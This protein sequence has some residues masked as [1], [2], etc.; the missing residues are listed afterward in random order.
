A[1]AL[2]ATVLA[3]VGLAIGGGFWLEWERGE[4]RAE[5]VRQEEREARAVEAALEQASALGRQGRWPDAR[6]VVEGGA[7]PVGSSA[8]ANLRERVMQARSDANMAAKLEGIRLRLSTDSTKT[9]GTAAPLYAEYAEAFRSYFSIDLLTL[10]PEEAAARVGNSAIRETL[11][12]YLHDWHYWASDAD[13]AKLQ[14]VLDRADDD[15]WRRAW[16]EAAAVRDTTVPRDTR[17]MVVLAAKTEALAQPPLVLSGLGGA[18]LWDGHR[19][20][21]LAFL[22]EAQQRHSED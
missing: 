15:P 6:A 9:R 2:V 4:R 22:R 3:L 12:A 21:T 20:E 11:L 8:P 10:D 18:L 13:R 5:A 16:R 17:R 19:E 1:A 14:A 7:R